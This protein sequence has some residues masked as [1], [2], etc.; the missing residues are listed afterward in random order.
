MEPD[1][2]VEV[3]AGNVALTRALKAGPHWVV[4]RREGTYSKRVGLLVPT[5]SVE[6][7]R[8]MVAATQEARQRARVQARKARGKA[9]E[10][11]RRDFAAAVVAYLEFDPAHAQLAAE[12]ADAVAKHACEVGSGRVGRAGA[13]ELESAAVAAA[14][15]HIRHTCTAYE[16]RL[17]AVR[18]ETGRVYKDVYNDVRAEAARSVDVFLRSHRRPPNV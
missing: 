8:A 11:Y 3:P 7:A 5:S 6:P 17:E 13:L 12:I 2:W 15:A 14:R 18:D 1:G 4:M 16:E 9:E 10:R